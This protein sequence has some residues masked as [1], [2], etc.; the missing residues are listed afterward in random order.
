MPV[1][2]ATMKLAGQDQRVMGI[3]PG[4]W[5]LMTGARELRE[6]RLF[7]PQDRFAR[8][9]E[10]LKTD[11]AQ[12]EDELLVL[13]A[14]DLS[15]PDHNGLEI[16]IDSRLSEAG[17]YEKGD[18]VTAAH[19]EWTITGIVDAGV[20]TRVF[21]PLRIAQELFGVGDITKCTMIFVKLKPGTPRGEAAQR[22]KN[23]FGLD[24]MPIDRYRGA[25]EQ[26]F[27]ILFTYVD[28]V[29][30]IALVMAFLFVMNTLYT[31]VLHRT[32]EIAIL[33]SC[34]ASAWYIL[35][36]IAVESMILTAIGTV[37]GIGASFGAG[38][39]IEHFRPLL[40]VEI[41]GQWILIATCAAAAG[42][43]LASLYP[44][45]G[46]TRVD[47]VEALTYE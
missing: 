9:L 39:A 30:A 3:H 8:W 28:A 33:K 12:D 11:P 26:K 17:G 18:K 20:A 46:A 14:E 37:L 10:K 41:S 36:Q 15:H 25:L 45:W 13:T 2:I 43:L 34:G 7:D 23:R 31:M 29:N 44:A 38:S 4:D 5:D 21:M 27:G 35:R 24:A 42:S 47:M 1:F 40:T 6:G 22:I 32:R 19:H 16:V